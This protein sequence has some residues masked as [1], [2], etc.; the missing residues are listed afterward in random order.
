MQVEDFVIQ[1]VNLMSPE[2]LL[3]G[4]GSGRTVQSLQ[5]RVPIASWS[6]NSLTQE[7]FLLFVMNRNSFMYTR[8]LPSGT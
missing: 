3:A 7:S 2:P 6:V 4:Q 1:T 8:L 5:P